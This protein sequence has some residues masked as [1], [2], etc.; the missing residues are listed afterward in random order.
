MIA[1][2]SVAI[3]R[4]AGRGYVGNIITSFISK[5]TGADWEQSS[6]YY[7][8][9]IRFNIDTIMMITSI[10]FFIILFRFSLSWFT[11]YFDEIV[12]GVDKLAREEQNPI[13]MC[14]ELG[15]MQE[16]LNQV[17]DE[18]GK[19]ENAR[20]EAEKRKNDLV[21]YL[22]HD[23]KTPLTSVI[24]YLNLLEETL[25]LPLSQKQKYVHITL[26]KAYRLEKLINEF[27][28]ITRYNLES[29]PLNKEN[30]DLYYMFI[31]IAD[32]AY[33]ALIAS[34][35][36]VEVHAAE[37]LTFYGDSDKL[38]R[39]FNNIIKNA[40]SYSKPGSTIDIYGE[41]QNENVIIRIENPGIIPK[42]QLDLIFEKFYRLDS[43]RSTS[44]GGAG[45]GLAIAK[46]IVKLHGGTI[47]ADCENGKII[48]K[49]TFPDKQ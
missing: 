46:D 42:E 29:I 30:I 14:P 21:V 41:V 28:E 11:R 23:I 25:E 1:V 4:S 20:M 40:I 37:D 6:Y 47:E 13:V 10:I 44:T 39:V 5:I 16:K 48:F 49:I 31:Q 3:L 22:A 43:A 7:Y 19:R 18:L 17:K 8:E 2:I 34:D 9:Y 35:K 27:F 33:P 32:E 12:E 24:G 45:L 15:F 36:K 38:A 26:E